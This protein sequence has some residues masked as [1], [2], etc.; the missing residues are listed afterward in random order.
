MLQTSH[1]YDS[2]KDVQTALVDDKTTVYSIVEQCLQA[3]K[4]L[5]PEINAV[6]AVNEDALNDAKSLDVSF[7][8]SST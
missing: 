3:I 1:G 2:I 7:H 6:L 8:R 4:T 5:N